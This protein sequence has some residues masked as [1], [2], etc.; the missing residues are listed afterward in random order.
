MATRAQRT[1]FAPAMLAALLLHAGLLVGGL[2]AWPWFNTPIP[3]GAVTAVTLVAAPPAPLRPAEQA[4]QAAPAAAPEPAPTPVAPPQPAPAPTPAPP[5]PP[6]KPL[7]IAKPPPE[8]PKVK[9]QQAKPAPKDSL[10]LAALTSSLSRQAARS[11]VRKAPGERGA[12]RPELAPVARMDPGAAEAAT[13]DAAAAVGARLN[14]IWNKSCGVEG[15]RDIVI[16]VRF[17]LTSDG[18]VDGAP[19]VLNEPA[20]PSAVWT[21]AKD[22]AVRAVFQASPFRELPRQTYATWRTFTAVFDAKQA[23]KNL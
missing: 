16:Q 14:R 15:F 11:D 22:R 1:N 20:A 7:P 6:T 5:P 3:P 21:A 19:Q 12:L 8:P 17:N 23:C 18:A 4:P 13:T 10:D 2:I 9:P